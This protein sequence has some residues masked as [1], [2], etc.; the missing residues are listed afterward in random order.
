[1]LPAPKASK[2]LHKCPQLKPDFKKKKKFGGGGGVKTILLLSL[3]A[4]LACMLFQY[5]IDILQVKIK[6][7]SSKDPAFSLENESSNTTHLFPAA[8]QVFLYY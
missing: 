5:I 3:D 7:D 8:Q 2:V 6:E 4:N 1:M